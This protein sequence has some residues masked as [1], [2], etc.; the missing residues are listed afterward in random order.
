MSPMF[1][2]FFAKVPFLFLLF[3]KT[4]DEFNYLQFL[5]RSFR[6]NAYFKGIFQ[7]SLSIL[8]NIL[9]I[10]LQ[11]L[12]RIPLTP[13]SAKHKQRKTIQQKIHSHLNKVGV[14]RLSL[15]ALSGVFED[16]LLARSLTHCS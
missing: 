11:R 6:L 13:N 7:L 9:Q 10:F 5:M 2:L 3:F 12:L 1:L 15:K 14:F 16:S 4:I 8:M